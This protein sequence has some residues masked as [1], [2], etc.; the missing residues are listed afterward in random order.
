MPDKIKDKIEARLKFLGIETLEQPPHL[1]YQTVLI[2][3]DLTVIGSALFLYFEASVTQTSTN[4]W[5]W[6]S[7]DHGNDRPSPVEATAPR[8]PRAHPDPSRRHA[9]A[10]RGRLLQSSVRGQ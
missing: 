7:L 3:R 8:G 1:G 6:P 5:V 2:A 9:G 4:V 10:H